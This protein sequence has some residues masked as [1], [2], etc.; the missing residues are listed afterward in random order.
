MPTIKKGSTG[1][2]VKIWQ[3]IL[4]VEADGI[5]GQIT[6]GKSLEWQKKHGL[7]ADGIIGKNTWN[8]ALNNL[9]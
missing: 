7:V 8:Y 4:G 3:I 2:A 1:K 5:F 6:H 9:K